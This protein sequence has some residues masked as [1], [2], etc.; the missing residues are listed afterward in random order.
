MLP[1]HFVG[2]AVWKRLKADMIAGP[3]WVLQGCASA[4]AVRAT[5]ASAQFVA[6][7]I[8]PPQDDSDR[9]SERRVMLTPLTP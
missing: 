6:R 3:A 1:A 8:W 4:A 5:C 7:G 9:T 2:D